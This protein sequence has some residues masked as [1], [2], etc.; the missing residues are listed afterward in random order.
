MQSV[1]EVK[2]VYISFKEKKVLK[3]VTVSLSQ[4]E[5]LALIGGS[6]E[7]KST[8]LRSIIGLEY[9]TSGKILFE[10]ENILRFS[11]EQYISV[12]KQISYVFQGGALFDS[13]T[14]YDNLAFPLREH[15]D[16]SEEKNKKNRFI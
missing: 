8:L 14:V 10:G 1:I 13:M 12:R 2:N 5:C 7:G 3:G 11:A 16:W 4:G 15:T 9:P 6:G